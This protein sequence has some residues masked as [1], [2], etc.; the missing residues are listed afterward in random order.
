MDIIKKTLI[1][2]GLS[3]TEATVY[4]AGRRRGSAVASVLAQDAGIKRTTV[5]HALRTLQ[6]KGLVTATTL[7]DQVD[8]F[9]FLSPET[10]MHFLEREQ[11]ELEQKK[12]SV[13][14]IIPFLGEITGNAEYVSLARQFQGEA[15]VKTAIDEALYCKSK[16]WNIIAPGNNI[17]HKL[18]DEYAQYFLQTRIRR[19]IVARSLWEKDTSRRHLGPDEIMARNPRF[20]PKHMQGKFRSMA[21][22]YD[23]SILF[24]SSAKTPRAVIVQS[25][26]F[27]S[28]M[29]ILFDGLW[30]IS[31]AYPEK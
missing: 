3:E 10:L 30:E 7:D 9:S 28:I 11:A 15:G 17:L 20:L 18:G 23:D 14:K 6:D 26:E 19:G 13:Q 25:Q 12:K 4:V 1:D 16:R 29:S 21:I 27:S 5:Y 22:M 31:E 8:S 2:L 24:V